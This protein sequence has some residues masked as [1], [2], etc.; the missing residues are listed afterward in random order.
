MR[1]LARVRSSIRPFLLAGGLLALLAPSVTAATAPVLTSQITD[2]TGVL[3][4]G[5]ADVQDALDD[6]LNQQNVQLWVVVVQTSN[7]ATA[8]DLATAIFLA[9][10]FGGN[11]MVLLIV[12]D[13]HKYGWAEDGATG[14]SRSQINSLASAQVEPYFKKEDY[15]GGI[16]VFARALGQEIDATRYP[17]TEPP[18]YTPVPLPDGGIPLGST[19]TSGLTTFLWVVIWLILIVGGLGVLRILF[20]AWKR[21]RLGA[22]EGDK[23]TGDLARQANRLL[24]DTDDAVRDAVAEVGFAEAAFDESDV[25]P[26]RDALIAAQAELKAAFEIRQQLDDSTPEDPP[27]KANM[28]GAIIAH[29]QA[30]GARLDEQAKRIAALR[31]LEKTAPA[32]LAELPKTIETLKSR[33]PDVREAMKTL[34]GYAPSSW[35]AVKGN[36]EEAD[37]RGHFAESQIE[38]GKAALAAKPPNRSAAA[39][40]ARAAQEA[41]AQANQLLDAVGQMAGALKDAD[42]KLDQEM[43]AAQA[44][45]KAART[46]LA[47]KATTAGTASSAA[48]LAKAED[49]LRTAKRQDAARPPDPLAALKSA[50]DAHATADSVLAGVR[51]A[52]DQAARARAAFDVAHA[53]AVGRINEAQAVIDSRRNG[54][55]PTARTRLAEAQRHLSQADALATTDIATATTEANVATNLAAS[56][57]TLAS[58]DFVDFERGGPPRGGY[59]GGYGGGGYGGGG[60]GGGEA[61]AAGAILGGIIGGILG[62]GIRNGGGFGGTPW[63]SS[64]GWSGGGSSGGG[65]SG[66]GSSSGG[67]S[68][69]FGGFGGHSG[70]GGWGVGGGGG[71]HGGGGGV[72]SGGGGW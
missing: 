70:G 6:L 24:V 55:G 34:M 41:V 2:Q 12:M 32:A 42:A 71:G 21:G 66:G 8:P 64:G 11:D 39:R 27:T 49:L 31:D 3:G 47:G 45:I 29:C 56:A 69:G 65:S 50:Q 18:V 4:S 52:S 15:S 40:A 68:S 14:L 57:Y 48:D 23:K 58:G 9:N 1:I 30:A 33:L 36:T 61:Q 67:S 19:D 22:E 38:Q 13:I 35:A 5:Q 16:V 25:K 54:V 51:E 44:D 7:G 60:G 59:G 72:H 26:Y 28:Y 53:S 63:G 20:R 46:A 17:K 43:A 10:G 62:G 37:K